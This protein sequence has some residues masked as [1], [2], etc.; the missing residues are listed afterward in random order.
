MIAQ[1]PRLMYK[2]DGKMDQYLYKSILEDELAQTIKYYKMNPQNIFFQQDN[3]TIHKVKII[4]EYLKNQK[5]KV[6]NQPAQSPDLNPIEHLWSLIKRELNK[7]DTPP[8]E[9]L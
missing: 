4:Q 9:M 3:C 6:L 1:G 7:Y 8:N 2:I 5:F